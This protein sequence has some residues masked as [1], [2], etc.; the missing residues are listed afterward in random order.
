M[1]PHRA[2]PVQVS[3]QAGLTGTAA[4][5]GIAFGAPIAGCDPPQP[6]SNAAATQLVSA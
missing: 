4:T 3:A 5:C 1:T 6:A 2:W